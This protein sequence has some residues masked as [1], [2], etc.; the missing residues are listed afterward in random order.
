MSRKAFTLVEVLI[1]SAILL[2]ALLGIVPLLVSNIKYNEW[3]QRKSLVKKFFEGEVSILR[4]FDV[5]HFTKSNLEKLGY[6]TSLSKSIAFPRSC[7]QGYDYSLY[8]E[9][10]ISKEVGGTVLTQRVIVKLC[11]DDDY[12]P[13]YLKRAYLFLYWPY[14]GRVNTLKTEFLITAPTE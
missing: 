12:M 5:F 11:V 2:I 1:A 3:L 14:R 8:K 13:P 9:D 4:T 10:L 7:P 6:S